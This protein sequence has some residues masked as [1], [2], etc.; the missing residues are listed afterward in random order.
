V[1]CVVYDDDTLEQVL[2]H[3]LTHEDERARIAEAGRARCKHPHSRP[4]GGS[5][6]TRSWLAYRN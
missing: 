1:E 6:W 2:E 5:M 4:S 3:Y